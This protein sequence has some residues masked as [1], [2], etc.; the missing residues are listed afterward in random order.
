MNH[1][2]RLGL[3][4][5]AG[6]EDVK[7]AYRKLAKMYHPD[8]TGGRHAD[9][10]RAIKDAYE[11]LKDQDSRDAYDQALYAARAAAVAAF[12]RK[13]N[14]VARIVVEV[15]TFVAAARRVRI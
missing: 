3:R 8:K 11:A 4:K 6:D 10:F 5:G 1:Y 7:T 9:R 14:A 13:V 12:V 2:T 15:L